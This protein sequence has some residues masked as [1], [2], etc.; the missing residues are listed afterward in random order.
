MA[1]K[2]SNQELLN[3]LATL[4]QYQ[5]QIVETEKMASLGQMVAGVAHEVNTPI[6]LGVTASTLL[7]DR[8]TDIQRAFT[9]KKLTS[10]Q[11]ERFLNESKEY[12][13]IVYRNLE[14]AANL[15]SSFKQ[16]AV[17]QSNDSQRRFNMAQLIN[18]V[19]F[20]IGPKLKETQHRVLVDCPP[21]L[22]IDSNPG[23]INQILIN[24]IMNSLIH[25]FDDNQHG[26]MQIIVIIDDSRCQLTYRDNGSGVPET[27]KKRIFDPFVT[28]KRGAGGSGLGMH[29]VYNLVTQ[30]LNGTIVFNSSLGD[31]VEILI[32]FPI[33]NSSYKKQININ[34]L[35]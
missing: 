7:Q 23:P 8:L 20:S 12:L 19:L 33:V 35:F 27:I 1:L 31:G 2:A 9:D 21:E 22:I 30:A 16:V 5:K 15:I 11:L 6:G 29:L 18:E 28:T 34:S 17:D 25:A 13:G 26:E 3:T 32:D 10:S 14:R 4:H 24:L